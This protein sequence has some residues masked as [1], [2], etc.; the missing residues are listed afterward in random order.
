MTM[1]PVTVEAVRIDYPK[2]WF[3]I[4]TVLDV[5]AVAAM[6]YMAYGSIED[7]ARMFWA[8]CAV[9]VGVPVLLILVPPMFTCH[10][11]GEK[12]LRLRMGLLMNTTIPYRYI[13]SVTD[14]DVRYGPLAVGLGV[15]YVPKKKL[16]FV[17]SAFGDFV[18]VR[19]HGPQQLGGA[20]RPMV[21]QVVMSVE[22]PE[23]FVALVRDRAGLEG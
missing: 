13:S 14:S 20:L 6:A 21:D 11:L 12:G 22:D 9:L 16:V 18:S 10:H 1:P 2:R 19:F 5:A 17:T 7:F 23:G 15:R 4:G 8:A 3:A